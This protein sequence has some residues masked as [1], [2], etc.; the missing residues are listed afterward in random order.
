MKSYALRVGNFFCNHTKPNL[1]SSASS[2]KSSI[3]IERRE[4]RDRNISNFKLFVT[5]E[6]RKKENR[7][8]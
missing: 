5:L 6:Y 2:R 8:G 4:S 7:E 1:L 3:A